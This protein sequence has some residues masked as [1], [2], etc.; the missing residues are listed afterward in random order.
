MMPSKALLLGALAAALSVGA[1]YA[2]EAAP[3]DNLNAV[4]WTQRSVEF[5]GN[6]MT[7]YALG[8]IRLDQALADKKWTAAPVEQTGDFA[9]LPPAMVLDN[10]AYQAW[11]IKAGTSFSLKTW[12]EFCDAQISKAVPGAVEF[13][14]YAESKGVKVFYLSNR[15]VTVEKSTR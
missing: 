8:M 3:N 12:N 14:K 1:A 10:S 13:A 6:A 15:D 9:N 5:K 7:V 11:N 2:Q 4:L